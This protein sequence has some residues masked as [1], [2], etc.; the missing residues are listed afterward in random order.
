MCGGVHLDPDLG[1][2]PDEPEV[3]EKDKGSKSSGASK[4]IKINQCIYQ[5]LFSFRCG[6]RFADKF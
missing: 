5:T 1:T 6:G 3:V 4:I 2:S